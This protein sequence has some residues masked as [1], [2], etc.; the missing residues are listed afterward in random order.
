MKNILRFILSLGVCLFCLLSFASNKVEASALKFAV[1]AEIPENQV[2]KQVTYFDLLMKPNQNQDIFITLTNDTDKEVTVLAELSNAITNSNGVV[3]YSKSA[4][5]KL[6]NTAPTS[7][8]KVVRLDKDNS[9][10]TLKPKSKQKVK[11]ALSMSGKSFNGLIAGGISFK[12]K[13]QKE[14]EKKEGLTIKNEYAYT[15]AIVLRESDKTIKPKLQLNDVKVGQANYRNTIFAKIQNPV[16][17]YINQ[18]EIKAQVF[19]KG[20][21][22]AKYSTEKK[23]MQVAPNTTF[24]FPIPLEGEKM[25][26]GEYQ[27]DL[28]VEGSNEKWHFTKDFTIKGDEAK[29]FNKKDVTL[30]SDDSNWIMIALIVAIVLLLLIVIW[31]VWKHKKETK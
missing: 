4:K 15:I 5:Y 6:D 7:I 13:P 24:D 11:L 14:A 17:R 22:K 16:A 31:L 26:T 19:K 3:E 9:E 20:E 10:I 28:K 2:D 18:M 27:L 30:K 25:E 8:E 12:E 1:E 29:E 23:E 21:K